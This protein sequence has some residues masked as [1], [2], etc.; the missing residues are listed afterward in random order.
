M[1]RRAFTLIELLVVIAIIAILAAI[2]FPVFAQ[3]KM[4]AKKTSAL[5]N[6][7]QL[8]LSVMMYM[9][10]VDDK[11]PV[12]SGECWYYPLDN[13]G[14]WDTQ[15]Y[16]K[17]LPV[18]RDP[19][20]PLTQVY[21]QSWYSTPPVVKIS[22]AG[23]SL[24][25][26]NGSDN[27]VVGVLNMG[28][29]RDMNGQPDRCNTGANGYQGGWYAGNSIVNASQISHVADTIMM[30]GAYGHNNIWGGGDILSDVTGWDFSAPQAIPRGDRNGAPYT[31]TTANGTDIVNADN[32]NGA[33]AS[34]YANKGIFAF[35]DG[36]V[37]TM[38]PAATRPTYVN[39]DTQDLNDLW[40]SRRP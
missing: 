17:N 28:Q 34:V 31:V 25:K 12:G 4:A 19:S 24:I 30:A 2:L 20:D 26:W 23:N 10:D 37:K 29:G 15:P 36:H 3:A 21:W 18:L 7:K 40:N 8:G 32:R 27:E 14:A 13:G 6:S 39:D 1:N 5:S 9:N 38:T 22:F 11:F 33:V 35:C 16:V